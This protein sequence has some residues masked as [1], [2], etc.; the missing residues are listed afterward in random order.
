MYDH[1]EEMFAE[2]VLKMDRSGIF[3][4]VLNDNIDVSSIRK[5]RILNEH[6]L[7]P[8]VAMRRLDRVDDVL[9]NACNPL[10]FHSI[11]CRRNNVS[12]SD[13]RTT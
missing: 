7:K 3:L 11:E 13:G 5:P 4:L 9:L 10:H 6:R 12:D 2:R 8:L 1:E